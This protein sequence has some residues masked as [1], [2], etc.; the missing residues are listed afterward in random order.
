MPMIICSYC[1]YIGQGDDYEDKI[2]D[3]ECHEES[4]E[5]RLANEE[6]DKIDAVYE[7]AR[8]AG[9]IDFGKS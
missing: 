8:D 2:Q 1:M 3:V 6:A 7:Q 9:L 4:C 5:E